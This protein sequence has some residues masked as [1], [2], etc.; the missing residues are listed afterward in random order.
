MG[1]C[2]RGRLLSIVC[3]FALSAVVAA[4][5]CPTPSTNCQPWANV[6]GQKSTRNSN[7][8]VADNFRVATAGNTTQVCWR[9][10]YNISTCPQSPEDDF[11]LVFYANNQ[12]IPGAPIGGPFRQSAGTLT[13]D[14]VVTSDTFA[15]Y[16][17]FEY[18]ASHAP[19]ALTANTCYWIEITNANPIS[20]CGWFW[21][22]STSGD[23]LSVLDLNSQYTTA[24]VRTIDVG[25]CLSL[26]L[27]PPTRGACFPPPI[28]ND[29]C[30][31][32]IAV[33]CGSVVTA[34]T[35]T[36]TTAGTDPLLPCLSGD[37]RYGSGTLWYSFVPT[38]ESVEIS[39]C[40]TVG[41]DAVLSMWS[42]TCSS[43]VS[44]GCSDNTPGCGLGGR[45]ARLCATGLTIGAT[46][47]IELTSR[48]DPTG[49]QI[50]MRVECGG[51][52][53]V[54]ASPTDACQAFALTSD[55]SG[56]RIADDLMLGA[57]QNVVSICVWGVYIDNTPPAVDA[58]EVTYYGRGP[59]GYPLEQ[60]HYYSQANGT[61][62]LIDRRPSGYSL[63]TG[64][65]IYAYTFEQSEHSYPG[66]DCMWLEVRN[67]A[68]AHSWRW[69]DALP[70]AGDGYCL[71]DRNGDGALQPPWDRSVGDKAW[72]VGSTPVL[73]TGCVS[74]SVANTQCLTA[75]RL[76]CDQQPVSLLVDN[77]FSKVAV[78]PGLCAPAV[79]PLW[80]KFRA[81]GMNARVSACSS[82]ATGGCVLAAYSVACNALEQLACSDSG[83]VNGMAEISLSQLL[84]GAEYFIMF[85]TTNDA[86]RGAYILELDCDPHQCLTGDA[87]ADGLV[88]NFDIDAFVL[89]IV[90]PVSY[91][92]LYGTDAYMC[93]DAN[94]D[95]LVN[96]FDIDAF[97]ACILALPP[98]GQGCP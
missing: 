13:V 7:R 93:N 78:P 37:F 52:T 18:T 31:T 1:T 55:M 22:T 46:Y 66:Y 54:C 56:A 65:T 61:L 50:E 98:S 12:G 14:R 85:A 28:P 40:S 17:V 35:R 82:P 39:T 92:S 62:V 87:N 29:G 77:M 53:T 20:N 96:N 90:N 70:G 23:S 8:R 69:C 95:G 19:V 59:D 25:F 15:G 68:G 63:A 27:A 45:G 74:G 48:S 9:G 75:V 51:C 91:M 86:A 26:P 6:D 24:D 43:L 4:Q 32:P 60:R 2:A 3:I 67:N 72:C 79:G 41:G 16:R 84:T 58:F 76:N 49:G 97:V 80:Y 71:I 34:D 47:L 57:E 11:Q 42:G 89:A 21:V 44:V 38:S 5:I 33:T 83:C 94:R 88:N 73:S 64:Q 81:T 36:A 10:V 30:A